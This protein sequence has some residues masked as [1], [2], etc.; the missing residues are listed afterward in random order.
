MAL[1][2][3]KCYRV[4]K[5]AYTRVSTSKPRKSYVKGVPVSKIHRFE[6]GNRAKVF[7]TTMYLVSKQAVNMRNNAMEAARIAVNK[8]LEKI[9]AENYFLKILPFPHQIMRENPMATGAGADR[10]QTGMRLSFGK[11]IGTAARIR[12]GQRI[13]MIRIDKAN[14]GVA[15][16][17]LKIAASKIPCTSLVVYQ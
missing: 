15:K 17:A 10:F 3:A 12:A 5:R 14:E 9:G 6:M 11:P 16:K 1:R 4:H 8:E 7:P 2:P 13:M